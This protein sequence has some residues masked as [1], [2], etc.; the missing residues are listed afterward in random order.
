MFKCYSRF[1]G[2]VISMVIVLCCSLVYANSS[3]ND[4]IGHWA[5]EEIINGVIWEL[6][7]GIMKILDQMII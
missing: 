5:E 3:Y 7:K 1:I 4:T 2:V 6:L